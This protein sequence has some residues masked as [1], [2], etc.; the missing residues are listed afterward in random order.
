MSLSFPALYY[1]TSTVF[2][3]MSRW[4]RTVTTR[5][6]IDYNLICYLAAFDPNKQSGRTGYP[7]LSRPFHIQR[8]VVRC[9]QLDSQTCLGRKET[10]FVAVQIHLKDIFDKIHR[11][12]ISPRCQRS[13]HRAFRGDSRR[14]LSISK[15]TTD[16]ECY[17]YEFI[18]GESTPKLLY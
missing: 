18:K 6:T 15:Q 10:H 1:P 14:Q 9:E 8:H 17:L 5:R 13:L 4:T 7:V 3:Y 16:Q 11:K 12:D 2:E